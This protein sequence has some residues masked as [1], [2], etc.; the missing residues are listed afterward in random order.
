M[1]RSFSI[2]KR[3][4]SLYHWIRFF[5]IQRVRG[6]DV[7][8]APH[9]DSD[10]TARW[11]TAQMLQSRKY[12]EW[13]AGGSTYLAAS[14]QIPFTTIDSDRYFLSAVVRKIKKEGL[15]AKDYQ[16]FLYANIGLTK[17]WG[18]PIIWGYLSKKRL[19][20]FRKYSDFPVTSNEEMPDL[21]LVDGRFRVACALKAFKVLSNRQEPWRLVVDDYTGR[22]NYAVLERFGRLECYVGR[23]AIFNGVA[24]NSSYE[25]DNAIF[26][27]EDDF[28]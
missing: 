22:P 5:Y 10:E 26:K 4:K 19:A 21:I 1:K 2:S 15:Y 9:F 7:P 18:K 16:T 8:S 23:M 28:R 14:N 17:V 11:F 20:S 6:F 12:F 24:V 27:Y 13:G 25:L 3:L